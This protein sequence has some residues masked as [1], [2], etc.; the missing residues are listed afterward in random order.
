[1]L[2][3]FSNKSPSLPHSLKRSQIAFYPTDTGRGYLEWSPSD[4][5]EG[6]SSSKDVAR[7]SLYDL[8]TSQPTGR[9]WEDLAF[10]VRTTSLRM[11]DRQGCT[12]PHDAAPEY[13]LS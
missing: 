7:A 12:V 11:V 5:I 9:L 4:V 2:G 6:V 10:V 1:M 3:N 8:I 13:R